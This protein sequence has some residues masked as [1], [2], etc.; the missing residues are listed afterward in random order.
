MP[1]KQA[2]RR[3]QKAAKGAA[4][5]ETTKQ[6]QQV[7]KP[8]MLIDLAKN[9]VKDSFLLEYAPKLVAVLKAPD[10]LLSGDA[11]KFLTPATKEEV[12]NENEEKKD[13]D[14][15]KKDEDDANDDAQPAEE[16]DTAPGA[17]NDTVEIFKAMKS[18]LVWHNALALGSPATDV[19]SKTMWTAFKSLERDMGPRASKRGSPKIDRIVTNL[20]NN[21][22]QYLHVLLFVFMLNCLLFRSWFACLPWLVFYQTLSL[23][24]PLETIEKVPQ[25]PLSKIPLKFRVAGT[26]A[27]HAL[28]WCF[29]LYEAI[30]K[31]HFL[32]EFW[33]FGLI[34]AH[35][36]AWFQIR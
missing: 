34:V 30:W 16:K 11:V 7:A 18:R 3:E 24:A 19:D 23:V 32:I 17:T 36:C 20:Y 14:D 31:C 33:A 8:A 9:L 21:L 10:C 27:I 28:V 5:E 15:A 1:S 12:K 4:V 29:F 6:P 22:P 13:E 26:M 2:V 25:V 35:A